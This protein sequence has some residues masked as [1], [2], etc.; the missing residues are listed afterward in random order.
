MIKKLKN[1]IIA[2]IIVVI[3]IGISILITTINMPKQQICEY[4]ID[5]TIQE[6]YLKGEMTLKY[7]N[8][9]EH[10]INELYFNLYPN[11]FKNE[12]NVLNV[13]VPD[14]INEAYPNGFNQGYI[15]VVS[16]IIDGKNAEYS[17]VDDEQVLKINTGEIKKNKKEEI[18]INFEEKLPDSPMRYG[19]GE[20][21]FNYGN[22]YPVLCPFENGEP[23]ITKYVSNGDP[24]YSECS[25]YY[26]TIKTS[27]EYRIATSGKIL[28]K[29]TENPMQTKWS[30]EGKN[31]RDFAFVLSKD[32]NLKSTKVGET[33]IYSY[34]LEND[35]AGESALKYAEKAIN[36]FNKMFGEYPYETFSVVACDFYIGG[37]EYP[38]LVYIDKNLYSN[39]YYEALEEVV[40]HETA[41]QWWYGVVGNNEQKEAWLDEG[42]T[43]FSV[44][45]YIDEI[46]GKERYK[47]YLNEN[48]SYCKTVFEIVKDVTGKVNKQIDRPTGEFEH[49]LLY[50]ALTYD[51]CALMF[52]NLRNSIGD[53]KLFNGLKS[54]YE[55]NKFKISNK[56]KFISDLSLYTGTDV[57][58]YVEPWLN[59]SIYWG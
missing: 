17:L 1:K 12:D 22:W 13:A 51:V 41:H 11:A 27:P 23:I 38:N 19:Y 47:M 36:C 37:M 26:V 40:V 44:A 50:D 52:D 29:N 53:D 15:N 57:N 42:L 16:V 55:A 32:F 45:L 7:V 20:S 25:D 39:I 54:Y 35:E 43:Q 14:R 24:F 6:E 30:I 48:E 5:A 46:Y 18:V 33:L 58:A 2:V 21:T 3:L 56:E 59:G 8:K 10:S 28:S 31:I 9:N 34:Y 49:W 4:Y